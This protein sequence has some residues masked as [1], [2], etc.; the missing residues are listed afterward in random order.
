M[1]MADAK[2]LR[3]LASDTLK[4][5]WEHGPKRDPLNALS[6]VWLDELYRVRATAEQA[7]AA[8]GDS[9]PCMAVWGPSQSGKSTLLSKYLDDATGGLH[10]LDWSKDGNPEHRAIFSRTDDPQVISLNPFNLRSDASGCVTRYVLRDDSEVPDHAHPVEITFSTPMQIMHALAAG[11]VSECKPGGA[12]TVAWEE[13]NFLAELR[14]PRER[15]DGASKRREVF[16][17]LRQFADTL[18]LLIKGNET[19]YQ[20]LGRLN[21]WN[22]YIRAQLLGQASTFRDAE[23]VLS[24]AEVILWNG[25]AELTRQ[26][27]DLCR[28]REELSEIWG[29][30]HIFCSLRTAAMLLDIGAYE[31]FLH[32]TSEM[33]KRVA[34]KIWDLTYD[35][36]DDRVVIGVGHPR[37]LIRLDADFGLLQGLV[38][39]LVVPLRKRAISA[40]P[41]SFATFIQ[42]ADLLDFP[43][44]ALQGRQDDSVQ[45]DL[46]NLKP[47]DFPRLL[48][49]VLKRGKTASVVASYA[50]ALS[51]DSFS[52]LLRIGNYP[53][54]PPQLISGIEMWWRCFD[55]TYDPNPAE[56]GR[57]P[58][59]LNIVLTFVGQLIT[60]VLVSGVGQ[61]LAPVRERIEQLG[62]IIHP[63]VATLF[64]TNYPQWPEGMIQG[65]DHKAPDASKLAKVK[66]DILEG[67]EFG[68][69]F[70]NEVSRKSFEA[71]LADSSGT[72]YL[73][74]VAA[75]QFNRQAKSDLLDKL[76][77]SAAGRFRALIEEALPDSLNEQRRRTELLEAVRQG[78]EAT[79]KEHDRDRA[80]RGH[81]D[82][83]AECSLTIRSLMHVDGAKLDPVPLHATQERLIYADFVREQFQRWIDTQDRIPHDDYLGLA[84]LVVRKRFMR[85]L[86]EATPVR[87]IGNWIR[88]YLGD[89]R[90]E[91]DAFI[92]RSYVAMRM[93]KALWQGPPGNGGGLS[94]PDFDGIEAAFEDQCRYEEG[95]LADDQPRFAQSPHYHAI[96]RA[97][98]RV[99]DRVLACHAGSRA[100]QSG[101]QELAEI[102]DR[103]RQG[104]TPG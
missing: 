90:Q 12:T 97:F 29:S 37:R 11:Y 24:M 48:T 101:D 51:I 83:A 53:A 104:P 57:P 52:I 49:Q 64:T 32:P 38:R 103:T 44:V 9:K 87:E 45:I 46:D 60:D 95:D 98:Q 25:Q 23:D 61:G 16:E 15:G 78:L 43:G 62:V 77:G 68:K 17:R 18:E 34:L 42:K 79:L 88:M 19:R 26:F 69:W 63:K 80:S 100:A 102:K 41:S 91:A 94:H 55:P 36:Q 65:P 86:V 14:K 28:K 39:E 22:S 70:S 84:D 30:R 33:A 13:G 81:R 47:L 71:M 27:K 50:S 1:T 85:Y 35:I 31:S 89:V 73:F 2:G 7:L 67:G 3:D 75:T 66:T 40:H 56:P 54:Q 74:E 76:V 8:G 96:V 20:N 99:L 93:S 5:F 59:P 92:A 58:L 4:W 21:R 72:D 10:P 6:S 82:I